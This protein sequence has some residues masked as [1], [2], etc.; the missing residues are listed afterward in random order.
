MH[1]S[2]ESTIIY[3]RQGIGP[4]HRNNIKN[5]AINFSFSQCSS[6]SAKTMNLTI[7]I[8]SNSNEAQQGPQ[9]NK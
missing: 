5:P 4:A 2:Y 9:G 8:W 1:N 6:K 3:D 7:K